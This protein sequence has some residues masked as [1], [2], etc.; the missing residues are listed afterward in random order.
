[1]S[2]TISRFVR[3][4]TDGKVVTNKLVNKLDAKLAARIDAVQALIDEIE[5]YPDVTALGLRDQLAELRG[6]Q[7]R[8]RQ[9][10]DNTAKSELLDAGKAAA[11]RVI[12]TAEQ[13]L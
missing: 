8:A 13:R 10:P 9:N 1:M 12:A 5:Q 11:K 4:M 6:I 3:V 7:A 2:V